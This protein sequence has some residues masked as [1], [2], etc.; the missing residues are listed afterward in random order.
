MPRPYL[1]SRAGSAEFAFQTLRFV[2]NKEPQSFQKRETLRYPLSTVD[3]FSL[4]YGFLYMLFRRS[5]E[6]SGT[7]QGPDV[8]FSARYVRELPSLQLAL[9]LLDMGLGEV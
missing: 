4:F 3:C 5:W 1:N 6:Q 7:E 2:L 9:F 8:D